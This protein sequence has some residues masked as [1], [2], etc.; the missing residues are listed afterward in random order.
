MKLFFNINVEQEV[1][2]PHRSREKTVQI[3]KHIRL[4]HNVEQEEQNPI[5]FFLR[6]ECFLFEQT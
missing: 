4:F 2:G 1:N 3:N 5:I 6:I